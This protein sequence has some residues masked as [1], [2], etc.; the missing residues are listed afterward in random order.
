VIQKRVGEEW[1]E[2]DLEVVD[3][4]RENSIASQ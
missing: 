4:I 2:A 3:V 1:S